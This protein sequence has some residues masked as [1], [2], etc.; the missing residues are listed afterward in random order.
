[1]QNNKD[2]LALLETAKNTRKSQLMEI[3]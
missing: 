3:A 2:G 1:L